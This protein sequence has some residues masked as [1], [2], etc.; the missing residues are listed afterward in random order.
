M[1]QAPVVQSANSTV[2]WQGVPPL[3]GLLRISRFLDFFPF[4][5]VTLQGSQLFQGPSLQS[6]NLIYMHR[7][8]LSN[9]TYFCLTNRFDY[10]RVYLLPLQMTSLVS[11]S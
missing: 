5:H 2:S 11:L 8:F 4:P 3:T 1:W 6:T 10:K 7:Q 9:H